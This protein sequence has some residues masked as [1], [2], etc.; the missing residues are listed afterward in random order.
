MR[1]LFPDAR[2]SAER[3]ALI[4]KKSLIASRIQ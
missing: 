1:A 2:H 4:F 3:F